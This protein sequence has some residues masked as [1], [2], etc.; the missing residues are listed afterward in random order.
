[1]AGFKLN[2]KIVISKS[3]NKYHVFQ[4]LRLLSMIIEFAKTRW[5]I[6]IHPQTHFVKKNEKKLI[7]LYTGFPRSTRFKRTTTG[8]QLMH[9]ALR[10]SSTNS[11]IGC[12]SRAYLKL[13][14]SA[15]RLFQCIIITKYNKIL[16]IIKNLHLRKKV[17]LPLNLKSVMNL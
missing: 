11:L 8:E 4:V 9:T 16:W 3:N 13:F 7:F 6:F 14:K 10:M 15:N 2:L 5:S 17:L 12:I 1:M